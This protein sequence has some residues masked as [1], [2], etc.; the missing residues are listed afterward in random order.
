[1]KTY[2]Y[3]LKRV[4][5]SAAFYITF[6][7]FVLT[8][9]Q[10]AKAQHQ[11]GVLAQPGS[12]HMKL[13]SIEV[14][15]LSDGSIPQELDK[16]LTNTNVDEVKALTNLNFQQPVVEAS[17]NAYIVK[18]GGKT[19]LID[20]GTSELYGPTLGHLP[21]NMKRAGYNPE[22]IEVILI[23]HI[24][25][26]HT[27]GLMD[28]DK[29]V[30]PNATVYVSKQEADYWLNDEQ[31][32]KATDK[33]KPYFD[34]A[35]LKMLPYLKAGKI[36]T[37]D[38]GKTLFPGVTPLASPGHTPGHSFYQVT[39]EGE[40]ILFWGDILHSGA[41]QFAKPEITIVYDV[42]PAWAARTRKK[43]FEQA[44]KEGYWI[45]ADH[46]S[47]PGIGHIRPLG[48]GYRWFPINYTTTGKGQ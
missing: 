15:A 44:A 21:A 46:L 40:K 6:T 42:D 28:G 7:V 45:A 4:K 16:L 35:R 9:M 10:V 3:L 33:M 41:V 5:S 34:Q 30:F 37:F 24:H 26:D 19:I 47:F 29:M 2:K 38:Y 20:A 11:E 22:E 1:M 48:K 39:S 12:Y 23:T 18:V 13:G 36:K 25:T 17:V 31:Y 32:A 8:F 14:I 43:A 27:G